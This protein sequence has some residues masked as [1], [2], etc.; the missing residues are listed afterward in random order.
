MISKNSNSLD[1]AVLD[2]ILRTVD[3]FLSVF[4]FGREGEGVMKNRKNK[5]FYGVNY[6]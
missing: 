2:F 5:N 4:C 3:S 6:K 1:F